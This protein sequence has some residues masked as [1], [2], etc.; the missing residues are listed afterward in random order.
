MASRHPFTFSLPRSTSTPDWSFDVVEEAPLPPGWDEAPPL[1]DGR[2]VGSPM[3][4][5]VFECEGG[6]VA[7][8][9]TRADFFIWPDRILCHLH[10]RRYAFAVELWLFG[11]VLSLWLERAGITT[12]HAAGVAVDDRVAAFLATNQGGKS[13][14]AAGM[15]RSGARLVTDDVLALTTEGGRIVGRPGYP[16]MRFWPEQARAVLG[17]DEGL[18]RVQPGSAKLKVPVGPSGFGAF[19]SRSLPLAAVYL[20]E[21]CDVDRVSIEPVPLA[22][23]MLALVRHAFLAGIVEALGLA[24]ARFAA[25]AALLR[26]APMRRLRYPSG[27]DRLPEVVAAIHLD[28]A[29]APEG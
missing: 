3:V 10:D 6:L 22:D 19:E 11:T 8:F 9:G 18:D 14:L 24:P 2:V 25:F 12:L 29:A 7:R 27:M 15:M 1:V 5:A 20:P 28:L 4:G 21:R 16:Q 17:R 13:T 23:A 26:Q